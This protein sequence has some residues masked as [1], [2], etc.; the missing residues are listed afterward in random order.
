MR[1]RKSLSGALV[2]E[3]PTG[4]QRGDVLERFMIY[5]SPPCVT[6]HIT[7][8]CNLNCVHCYSRGCGEY[9][10]LDMEEVNQ[11][12]EGIA[13]ANIFKVH[14]GGGEPF[15]RPDI[16]EIIASLCGRNIAVSVSTN[17]LLVDGQ[18]VR[19]LK[20]AGLS[21]VYISID[22]VEPA[23]HDRIRGCAGAHDGT[24][25]SAKRFVEAGIEVFLCTVI[26]KWNHRDIYK[27]KAFGESLGIF[28]MNAKIF[29]PAGNGQ[30][31]SVDFSIS[32]KETAAFLNTVDSVNNSGSFTVKVEAC[33]CKLKSFIILPNGDVPHCCYNLELLGS[34]LREDIRSI[35]ARLVQEPKCHG[36]SAAPAGVSNL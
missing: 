15:M 2:Q 33:P 30:A 9:N 6:W 29:R 21:S 13:Q 11:I 8:L 20:R 19:E 35:W 4:R 36:F 7:N 10:E 28:K 3:K 16:I 17:G 34:A 26:S 25:A 24:V 22:S 1:L 32:Q 14:F 23:I 27:L 18:K 31:S 5:S 12:I